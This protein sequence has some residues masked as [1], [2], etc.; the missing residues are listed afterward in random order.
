MRARAR[1][2][3]VTPTGTNDNAQDP[4]ALR[5]SRLPSQMSGWLDGIPGR[6]TRRQGDCWGPVFLPSAF[7]CLLVSPVCDKEATTATENCSAFPFNPRFAFPPFSFSFYF[8]LN[9]VAGLSRLS[10]VRHSVNAYGRAIRTSRQ[11]QG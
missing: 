6:W 3:G 11:G 5:E 8:F 2:S 9:Y 7:L 10:Q 4:A 1:R